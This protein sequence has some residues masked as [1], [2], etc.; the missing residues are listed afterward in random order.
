[1]SRRLR[2]AAPPLG[3]QRDVDASSQ[4]VKAAEGGDGDDSPCGVVEV[5]RWDHDG[6]AAP[7]G[8]RDSGTASARGLEVGT[9]DVVIVA[10]FD[11]AAGYIA[12]RDHPVH[13]DLI[14][15]LTDPIREAR[16]ALQYEW[17]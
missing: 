1:M 4:E 8:R 6:A 16:V 9:F 7:G 2:G 14:Q 11:D 17:S 3:N 5:E 13:R 10:D 15:R 12:Y